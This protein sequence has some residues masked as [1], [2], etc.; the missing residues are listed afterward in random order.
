MPG[1]GHRR[2]HQCPCWVFLMSGKPEESPTYTRL[3]LWPAVCNGS[4][5]PRLGKLVS[6]SL[7]HLHQALSQN[8][9]GCI[10]VLFLTCKVKPPEIGNITHLLKAEI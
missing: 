10:L 5:F 3:L 8:T 2:Q 9:L 7:M 4:D 6:N 1:G